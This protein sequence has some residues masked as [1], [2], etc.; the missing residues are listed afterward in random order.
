[1]E[2]KI[3]SVGKIK[4]KYLTEGIREYSKRLSRYGKLTFIQAADEKTPDHASEAQNEQIR[5]IEGARLLKHI[6]E[7]DYVIA[8]AI[9]GGNAGF[10]R[11]F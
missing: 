10:C 11:T 7:Q 4:E 3:L 5:D 8:L 2:I 1:M 6:R 9:Q